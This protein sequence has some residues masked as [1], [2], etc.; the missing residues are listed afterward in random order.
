MVAVTFKRA[1][2]QMQ[3]IS[4]RHPLI[5]QWMKTSNYYPIVLVGLLAGCVVAPPQPVVYVSRPRPAVYVPQYLPSQMVVS[6]YEDPPMS[7]PEPILVSW[8]PPPMLVESPYDMP[9]AGAVWIGGYWVWNGNWV[10]A[11]GRWA[12]APRPNYYWVHPYY[13]NRG[14]NVVFITGYW[15]PPT[16]VF[17]AP[18]L[19]VN[20]NFASVALG[21][22]A[23]AAVIGP[24]GVFVPAP[25]GSR[26]GLIVP[27]PIGTPP[28]VVTSAPPVINVGMRIHGN[29]NSNTTTINGNV[30]NIVTNTTN[31]TNLTIMA[32]ASATSSGQAVNTAVPARAHL[33]AAMRPE[34]NAMA[35]KPVSTQPIAAYSNSRALVTLPPAQSVHNRV[36]PH[37][38]S[39]VPNAVSPNTEPPRP[40]AQL[41]ASPIV[42]PAAVPNALTSVPPASAAPLIA[43]QPHSA[44]PGTSTGGTKPFSVTP[45]QQAMQI[46]RAAAV[47]TA[48]QPKPLPANQAGATRAAKPH[49]PPKPA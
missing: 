39:S 46:N 43:N 3:T 40:A 15:S 37:G 11:H 25:P 21:V 10:W 29:V 45:P 16:S 14:G 8:A 24:T 31:V 49:P 27:A 19:S 13:E 5:F 18:S 41:V 42:A 36:V 2:I 17:I 35:P 22:V 9:Y 4:S 48:P 38:G 30:T 20:I 26:L 32:P 33:A 34:V 47:R 23:G 12:G 6:V 7:Q 1:A 28:A 44:N